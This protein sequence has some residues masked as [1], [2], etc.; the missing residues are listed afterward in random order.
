MVKK[1]EN[2]LPQGRMLWRGF[3]RWFGTV[4]EIGEAAECA[5]GLLVPVRYASGECAVILV[6][7]R[8]K[9]NGLE[10][11]EYKELHPENGECADAIRYSRGIPSIIHVFEESYKIGVTNG[12]DDL[13][14]WVKRS[15]HSIV[16]EYVTL[17]P[18]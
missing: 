1:S 11:Y 17:A 5:E 16:H 2:P 9:Y 7:E 8:M 3:W 15:P 4:R 13:V 14:V 6:T 12:S 10:V 18:Q